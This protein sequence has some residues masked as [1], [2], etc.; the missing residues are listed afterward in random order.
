ML[1]GKSGRQSG[2]ESTPDV[3]GEPAFGR[4][5]GCAGSDEGIRIDIPLAARVVVA[6]HRGIRCGLLVEAERQIA[7]DE[8]FQCFGNMP[9]RLKI[10][11]DAFEPVH[12]RHILSPLQIIAAY[13]HLLAGEVIPREIQLYLGVSRIFA[14]RKAP[15]NV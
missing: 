10:I 11:N 12:R 1:W 3:P 15:Y 7:L 5:T 13:L 2:S 14:I 6:E 4:R 9:R 8:T